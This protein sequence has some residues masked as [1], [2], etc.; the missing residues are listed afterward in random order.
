MIKE[1]QMLISKKELAQKWSWTEKR[2]QRFL[3]KLER[4]KEIKIESFRGIGLMITS[5]EYLRLKEEMEEAKRRK[6][7][8][9]RKS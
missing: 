5:L 8:K 1:A 3:Q 2:V 9:E 7:S 4:E 6:K